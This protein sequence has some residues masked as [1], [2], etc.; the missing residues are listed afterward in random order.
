VPLSEVEIEIGL[1]F[2]VNKGEGGGHTVGDGVSAGDGFARFCF[3]A[4][5]VWHV[6]HPF[7]P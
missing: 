4:A 2:A 6:I 7:C 3:N 5:F 1:R